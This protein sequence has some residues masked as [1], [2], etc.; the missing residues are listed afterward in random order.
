M[1]IYIKKKNRGKFGASASR[2]GMGTQ[3]YARHILANKDDYSPIQVK[4][5]T[6]AKGIGGSQIKKHKHE[7]GGILKAQE[8]T[9]NIPFDKQRVVSYV[10]GDGFKGYGTTGP[11]KAVWNYFFN[12]EDVLSRIKRVEDNGKQSVETWNNTPYIKRAFLPKELK[13]TGRLYSSLPQMKQH[14]DAKRLYL[15]YPMVYNTMADS[16]YTPTIGTALNAKYIKDMRGQWYFDKNIL[17]RY[18]RWKTIQL[19]S[20]NPKKGTID[21]GKTALVTNMPYLDDA[22][23]SEGFDDKGHY[24]SIYDTW[25]YNTG[26]HGKNGDNVGKHVGGKSF[27]IYDRYYLDDYFDVPEESRGNPFIMPSRI[28]AETVSNNKGNKKLVK[29]ATQSFMNK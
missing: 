14:E 26:V 1:S 15:G 22:T 12:D 18:M 10:P 16:E 29:P 20:E 28:V 17:P 5:A 11:I 7:N 13:E 3:E 6:F 2:A 24:I 9:G 27:D 19:N 4:R 23:M 25:D 21:Y 8:G